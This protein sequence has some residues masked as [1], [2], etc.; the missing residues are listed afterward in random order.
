MSTLS[1]QFCVQ[2]MR[3]SIINRVVV[4]T[5][6]ELFQTA[7]PY[8]QERDTIRLY[9]DENKLHDNLEEYYT[10]NLDKYVD[11][12]NFFLYFYDKD[13]KSYCV[14]YKCTMVEVFVQAAFYGSISYE[15]SV[16]YKIVET[17]NYGS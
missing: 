13:G 11:S 4:N 5:P 12:L 7:I 8:I 3:L 15:R 17:N 6:K 9:F 14:D 2:N 1:F 16:F 10:T